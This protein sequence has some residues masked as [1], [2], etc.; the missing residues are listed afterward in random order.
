VF[1]AVA[2][3]AQVPSE[4][5]SV[6]LPPDPKPIGLPPDPKPIALPPT[7]QWIVQPTG[8]AAAAEV[9]PTVQPST[10]EPV[11]RRQTQAVRIAPVARA[12]IAI[13]LADFVHAPASGNAPLMTRIN[14]LFHAGDGSGRQ[15]VND[16]R[17]RIYAIRNGV[18]LPVPFLDVVAARGLSVPA[19]EPSNSEV[20]L[21]TFAF[22]PDFSRSGAPGYGKFYTLHTEPADRM[23][24]GQVPV[25]RGPKD[26]PHHNNVLVEWS[27]DPSNPDRIVPGSSREILR[28]GAHSNDNGGGQLGFDP[29]LAPGNPDYGQLYISV[30]DGGNTV[31]D[32]GKVEKYHLAQNMMSA[33]GKILRI[34]PLRA[35][36]RPYSV[37]VS[38]PFLGRK[39]VLPEIW[40]SGLR[41]PQRFSWD[42]GGAKQMLIADIGQANVEE[43][44]LG[45]PGANYGW[46]LYEGDFLVDH[47]NQNNLTPLPDPPAGFAFPVAVYGHAEGSAVTGGFV[48]R[49]KQVPE[50][51]GKYIFGDLG[52]GALF[53]ADAQS[54]E[55]GI[56][57][58]ISRLRIFYHG[59]EAAN[60][61]EAMLKSARADMRLGMGEDGDIYVLTKSDG[62]IRKIVRHPR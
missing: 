45:K 49:G 29:N 19:G 34:N 23:N 13:E 28:L 15:F 58:P 1:A 47:T 61:A 5:E 39:D 22:H 16:M 17:G 2:A 14:F 55:A 12:D 37:P 35:G 33:F 43:I 3:K 18:L 41:N 36:E 46:G 31:W 8:S 32:N 59:A 38:N 20:G 40:A 21:I 51:A 57:T 25:F 24:S 48:Y 10:P 7:P 26:P 6:G 60:V 53:A 50:L 52:S 4:R 56:R 62:G 27:V 42:R 11:R 54:L 30:G 44:N 9:K